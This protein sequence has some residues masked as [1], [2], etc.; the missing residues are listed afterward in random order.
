MLNTMVSW[1]IISNINK[2]LK[3]SNSFMCTTWKVSPKLP[4]KVFFFFFFSDVIQGFLW[5]WETMAEWNCNTVIALAPKPLFVILISKMQPGFWE[6]TAWEGHIIRHILAY[7]WKHWSTS[8]I[9]LTVNTLAV[10]RDVFH[11]WREEQRGLRQIVPLDINAMFALMLPHIR[12]YG[13]FV[14]LQ[15]WFGWALRKGLTPS[16]VCWGGLWWGFESQEWKGT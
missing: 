12:K 11:E 15:R 2:F 14:S 3:R 10:N 9:G 6:N 7:Y 4:L 8:T 1:C 13:A 5:L 16:C